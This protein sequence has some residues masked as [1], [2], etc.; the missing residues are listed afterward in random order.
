MV[1][2]GTEVDGVAG[3][4]ISDGRR[5]GSSLGLGLWRLLIDFEGLVGSMRLG[6]ATGGDGW[7]R[8]FWSSL[9]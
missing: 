3:D 8:G 2:R 1:F 6:E 4:K 5:F 9:I 7:A